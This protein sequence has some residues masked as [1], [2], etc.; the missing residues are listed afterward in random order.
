[1][2]APDLNVIYMYYHTTNYVLMQFKTKVCCV[3]EKMQQGFPAALYYCSMT[4]VWDRITL[5]GLRGGYPCFS[6]FHPLFMSTCQN[7]VFENIVL[8]E[9]YQFFRFRALI[10]SYLCLRWQKVHQ[11]MNLQYMEYTGKRV[12]HYT[13]PVPSHLCY[14]SAGFTEKAGGGATFTCHM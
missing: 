11:T 1:M 6:F 3:V 7:Q 5:K 14:K 8:S 13:D 2:L 10:S 12:L 9:S 4:Y